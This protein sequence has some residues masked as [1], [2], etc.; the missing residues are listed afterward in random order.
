M[1]WTLALSAVALALAAPSAVADPDLADMWHPLAEQ[2]D[3]TPETTGQ[4][5]MWSEEQGL[6]WVGWGA[7]LGAGGAA[8]L[9]GQVTPLLPF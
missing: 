8:N 6:Y 9:G 5:L 4:M 1:R 2:L 3:Q 7:D